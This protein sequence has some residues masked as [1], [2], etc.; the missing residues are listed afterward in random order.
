MHESD[1]TAG[2]RTTL[3]FL[4]GGGEMG[5]RMRSVDWS[6]TA[7]GPVETWPQSLRTVISLMLASRFAMVIAWGPEFRF[8][9]NDRYRPVLGASKHPG[10]LA[11]PAR[12]IFPE[13]WP[14][15]GPLFESTR[16]G[17]TFEMDD[18]LVPLERY[19]YLENCYFTLS[20]SPIRDE[21][22]GVG[23]MLAVVAETTE[24]VQGERRLKTLRDLAR[25]AAEGKSVT[26]ACANAGFTL[27][28][29]QIDV[30]FALLYLLDPS[31]SRAKL[32]FATGLPAGTTASPIHVAFDEPQSDGWPLRSVARSGLA[33]IVNDLPQRFDPLP[34]G[35][36]PETTHTALLVP[37]LRPGQRNAN[38]ILVFGVSPRRALDDQYRAFFDLAADHISTAVRNALAFQEEKDRAERLAELDRAKTAFFSNVSHEFRTPLTLMLGPLE[39]ALE[40]ETQPGARTDLE[41]IHR[42]G[43]RLLRLVNTLLDFSRIEAGRIQAAYQPTELG[44]LTAELA[45]VFRSAIER[46]GME[47]VVDCP[48]IAEPVY[49]DREMWEKIVL[50][51]LSNA[52]KFT[53]AGQIVVRLTADDE[54][55]TLQVQDTGTGI[56]PE[57]LPRLFERFHRI[58]GAEARAHEGSGIGLA[59]V[60][61][62][63]K[64]H[65]GVTSVESEFGK[66]T[67][68]TVDIPTGSA[69]LPADRIGTGGGWVE[70][71]VSAQ[72]YADEALRWIPSA[73]DEVGLYSTIETDTPPSIAGTL[74][75]ARILL[76]D[77]NADMREYVKRILKKEWSVEAVSD[78]AAA[79]AAARRDVPDLVLSD[80]MM[81][82]L[83][84]FE[85]LR[86]LRGDL[87][88]RDVPVI[89]LSA[90]AG[91]ESRIEGLEAGADDYLVKP[92][93]ARELTARITAHLQLARLRKQSRAQLQALFDKMPIG[94]YLVDGDFR[95]RLVNPTGLPLFGDMPD[96]IGRDFGQVIHQLRPGEY[97]EEIVALFRHTLA[98]GEPYYAPER[99]KQQFNA[100]ATE[101]FEWQI[102]R[103]TM[104]EGGYGVVCYFR[105]ISAQVLARD[106]RER[107]LV[108]EREAH[109]TADAASRAKDEFLAT[110]SHELRNPLNAMLG[111]ARVLSG[112]GFDEETVARGLRSIEQNAVA[113]AQLIEDLLDVSR[114]ISGKF[115]LD[116]KPVQLAPVIEAAVDSIRPA[117][118]AKRV[119]LELSLDATAGLVA[120][121]A[122]RLQQ[123]VWN[124][125]S[126][127]VKFTP[128]EGRVQLSLARQDDHVDITV[129]DSGQGIDPNFL[130]QVFNRFTQADSSSTRTHGGLGLG[131]AIVRHISELHGGAVTAESAG[132]GQ[133]AKFTVKLP[134]INEFADPS[135]ETD[136][137]AAV[138]RHSGPLRD[139][140]EFSLSGVRILVVDDEADTR[141]LLKTV[142][143]NSGAAVRTADSAGAG[144]ELAQRWHPQIIVS[145]IGMPGEDGYSFMRRVQAWARE[146]AVEVQ[147]VAL[148][149][150]A[151]TEDIEQAFAAGYQTHLAKPFEPGELVE[152]LRKL[153]ASAA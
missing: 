75:G 13:A 60:Q 91:E 59:L 152:R 73:L 112:G 85:L 132:K 90:R 149:A 27:G 28:E 122:G 25:R 104:P 49:V 116:S 68:F 106:E 39:D 99:A 121:D 33:Q 74:S 148:T 34:G 135:D 61:E 78:G 142:L 43:L 47:L 108:A 52:F 3:D 53:F 54:H 31:G 109:A 50:N 82:G 137:V 69:H 44:S 71:G 80:V 5:E 35:P 11:T 9:Y 138:V 19:G 17:E 83:D 128:L 143:I 15:I 124:L 48:P 12:E 30:P 62:L 123:V 42:N 26:E 103:I 92:F 117:A 111:W 67:T 120:G 126:N 136:Q 96:L 51:L 45:S 150:Y 94:V 29:N 105:D 77:D 133:G 40:R 87:R 58:R 79:L 113:Q 101:F 146:S 130:P 70:P 129:T 86:E 76:A 127:A 22:G 102:N 89:F 84:G 144:L 4:S 41:V 145:D 72:A 37:L 140:T 24:R 66:G 147:A 2:T 65:G 57:E 20:Y 88:T 55:V 100:N 16:R 10:A 125:L 63:V 6:Q 81:P 153:A 8:F 118:E 119:T 46:V 23:G 1:T 114:I 98:S 131:L 64:L 56:P 139:Q 18:F 110:V 107:L 97:A 141:V 32:E 7:L 93:S 36:Y 21:S 14:Q 134:I 95:I 151:R 115:R 38:G